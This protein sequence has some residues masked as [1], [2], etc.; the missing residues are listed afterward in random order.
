[1]TGILLAA[2]RS[3]RMGFDKPT[4]KIEG[5]TLVERHVRQLRMAGVTEVLAVCNSLNEREI[6]RMGV[7]TVLQRGDSMSAAVLTGI[8]EAGAEAV[9]AVC[10]NDIVGDSDYR[11]IFAPKSVENGIFIPTFPLDRTFSGGCLDLD[12]ETG[13]VRR[14]VEKP[15]GGCPAGAPANIMIHRI[16][17]VLQRLE[18][19]LRTGNEYEA[20][21][22]QL[23]QEGVP[24]KAIQVNSW[25]AIK[26]PADLN[27]IRD[28]A[29]GSAP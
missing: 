14:I 1:M 20:A 21:L 12:P 17:G 8:E 3:E 4:L 29:R 10:V 25:I 16:H 22:N 13:A 15:E 26:T 24:A 27:R 2:G 23:I 9:C 19:L 6:G 28:A 5:E 18:E 11:R 7:Q